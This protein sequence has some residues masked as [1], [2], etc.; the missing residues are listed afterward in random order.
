MP[1]SG[2]VLDFDRLLT[3]VAPDNPCGESL[4]WDPVWDELSQLRKTSKDPLDSSAD[5]TPEWGRVVDLATEALAT[6]TKDLLIAGWLTEAL[7]REHGFAG[8]RDGL[9]LIRELADRFWEGLHPLSEDG[10][11][12]TRSAPLS[13][14]TTAGGG[15][16]MPV[17]LREIPLAPSAD[18]ALLNW[19]FWNLR[20]VAPQGKDEKE[21]SFKRR[22]AEGEQKRQLFDSAVDGAP[23]AYFQTLLADMD[24]CLAEIALLEKLLDQKLADQAPSWQDLRRSID[25]IRVFVYGV[26]KRRG[27]LNE[28]AAAAAA[29]GTAQEAAVATTAADAGSAT[30]SGPIRSR[31]DA[32]ARLEEAAEFFHRSEPHSP[33]AYLVRRAVRWAGM[34]FEEVLAE[35]V[36]DDKLVKQ[37]GE[38]LGLPSGSSK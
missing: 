14:L 34:P 20:R 30:G 21:D 3:P 32:I 8:F 6:R 28:P 13:W 37:I 1:T 35:L 15:A 29:D 12:A 19:N 9:R 27:G 33:V 23:I 24:A 10:D 18:G 31:S 5:K 22:T 16:R 25:E 26:L 17:A 38:T 11:L 2:P 36:K 7:V 4:R